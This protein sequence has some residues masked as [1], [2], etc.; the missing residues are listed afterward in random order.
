MK[1]FINSRK[2]QITLIATGSETDLFTLIVAFGGESIISPKPS[3]SLF[4]ALATKVFNRIVIDMTHENCSKEFI[5]MLL[6]MDS[7]KTI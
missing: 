6:R 3:K 1:V 5:Q 2:K 7:F 4:K